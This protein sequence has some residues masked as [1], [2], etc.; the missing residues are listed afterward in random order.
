MSRASEL[1][2]RI[3]ELGVQAIDALVADAEA[4]QYFLDFKQSNQRGR[5][6]NLHH[7]DATNLSKAISAFGN[8]AGGILIW[9]IDCR[10][11]R[12]N[13]AATYT[14]AP[15]ED[16]RAFRTKLEGAV[17]R[18]SVPAHPGVEHEAIIVNGTE[19]YVATHVPK[20]EFAP[21]R[22]L[23]PGTDRYYLRAG[24][25]FASIPHDALA[26]LFGRR[27]HAVLWPQIISKPTARTRN[28]IGA[29]LGLALANGGQVLVQRPYISIHPLNQ[30]SANALIVNARHSDR[31]EVLASLTKNTQV[32]SKPDVVIAPGGWQEF[33]DLILELPVNPVV[34]LSFEIT[35]G[36]ENA[37]P[38]KFD[39]VASP[40]RQL[41]AIRGVGTYT[42]SELFDTQTLVERLA[43]RG[44]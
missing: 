42:S 32:V 37:P 12:A 14:R 21:V 43:A 3:R 17:S 36:C 39:L 24:S 31:V 23:A 18:L 6:P 20:A 41:A 10:E 7:D 1:F 19:G 13:G 5:A 11:D 34:N 22:A 25:S 9:G 28:S 44:Y 27:P 8:S 16:A 2:K 26:G 4:E 30:T 33:L 35:I 29:I 40:D 38:T 15:L